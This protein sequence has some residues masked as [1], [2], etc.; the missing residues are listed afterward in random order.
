MMKHDGQDHNGPCNVPSWT[1]S[2]LYPKGQLNMS[3]ILEVQCWA[4][5]SFY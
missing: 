4:V 1:L 5:N 3:D 2:C